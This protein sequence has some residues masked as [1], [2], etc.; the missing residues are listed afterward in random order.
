MLMSFHRAVHGGMNAVIING[1]NFPGKNISD[2]F[3]IDCIQSNRFR[4]ENPAGL[5][6]PQHQR[7]VSEGIP[8]SVK[9]LVCAEHDS[10][11]TVDFIHKF[12]ELVFH[13]IS[14]GTGQQLD[15]DFRIHGRIE[16]RSFHQQSF[17]QILRVDQVAV[18]CQCHRAVYA[19]CL[20][21]L[22][23]DGNRGTGRGI[24]HVTDADMAYHFRKIAENGCDKAHSLDRIHF[25]SIGNSDSCAFLAP[26]LQRK[27]PV[28]GIMHRRSL[29]VENAEYAA[30]FMR[31]IVIY[32]KTFI[33]SILLSRNLR[34]GCPSS[35]L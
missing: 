18:M 7:T 6:L 17:S 2:E 3:R 24:A 19:F 22:H 12:P 30:F 1:N 35:F 8:A 9:N 14:P 34:A 28:V 10:I 11:G 33:H 13:P 4:S 25:P 5:C 27:D 21:G 16:G 23:I 31:L 32:V 26:V 20:E 29:A 15:Q